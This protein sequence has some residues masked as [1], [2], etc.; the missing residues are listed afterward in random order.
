LNKP[1]ENGD[2]QVDGEKNE[3]KS[4]ELNKIG[5]EDPNDL[6]V[7]NAGENPLTVQPPGQLK[8]Q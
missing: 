2:D 4:A 3:E 6:S 1:T 5:N 7:P 8:L